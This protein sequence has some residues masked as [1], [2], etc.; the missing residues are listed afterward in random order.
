M[1]PIR[2]INPTRIFPI[3][4]LALIAAN[5]LIFFGWQGGM[6]GAESEIEDFLY[7]HAAVACELR[8]GDPLS[9]TEID[10][11]V[12]GDSG[13]QR[14]PDKIPLLSAVISMF[15]HGGLVHLFGNMWFL[16]IF[17]NNVE[18]AFGSLGYLIMYLAA[19]AAATAAFV[20]ANS[21]STD[22]LVGASGAIAGVLGAYLVLFPTH[23]VMSLVFFFFV[24]VPAI[25][26]LG[27][28]FLTQFGIAD[29]SIAWE[30]HV[31]GFVFGVLLTLPLRN[32][33]LSRVGALHATSRYRV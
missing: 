22:P 15:L 18:E 3:I 26:F 10:T 33:L 31:G 6:T 14:H 24:P 30:A 4:T 7:E 5:V 1:F 25:V 29:A 8:S 20:F 16:W 13:A 17:G 9:Q 27:I 19:G 21:A 28:W 12:C 2:D 11:G 32:A 23:R